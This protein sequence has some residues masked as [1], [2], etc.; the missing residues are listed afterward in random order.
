MHVLVV[1]I[2]IMHRPPKGAW[3]ARVGHSSVQRVRQSVAR[4]LRVTTPQ[5][6][7]AATT[8]VLVRASVLAQHIVRVVSRILA[9]AA[10]QRTQRLAKQRR[11]S[12]R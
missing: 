4:Y 1:R 8:T 10:I 7:T 12:A 6:A 3:T 5:V 11:A 9:L 2:L